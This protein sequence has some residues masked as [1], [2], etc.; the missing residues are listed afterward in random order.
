MFSKTSETSIIGYWVIS[1]KVILV[2]LRG[3]PFNMNIIQV[4]ASKEEYEDEEVD[5]FYDQINHA[6][7]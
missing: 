6:V 3:K 4:C 5:K 7:S 1:D 2:K